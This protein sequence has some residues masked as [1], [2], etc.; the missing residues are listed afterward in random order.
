MWNCPSAP[1][2]AAFVPFLRASALC[3]LGP[4]V[5]LATAQA[6]APLNGA[7]IG[8]AVR[9]LTPAASGGLYWVAPGVLGHV[10]ADGTK[11]ILWDGGFGSGAVG[12]AEGSDGDPVVV[13]L[14][15]N[16]WRVP[17][18]GG[19][20]E[21]IYSDL[22]LIGQATDLIVDADGVF[23]IPCRTPSSGV[24]GIAAVDASAGG[25]PSDRRW[26]FWMVDLAH[27]PLA[28]AADAAADA[29]VM[30]DEGPFGALFGVDIE[31]ELGLQP[32]PAPLDGSVAFGGSI[33]A[34]DGDV[35]VESDGDAWIVAGDT[36]WFHDRL[37]GTTL[38]FQTG[39]SVV[40]RAVAIAPS[41]PSAVST[42]G[43]SLWVAERSTGGGQTQ[44]LEFPSVDPGASTTAASIGGVVDEGIPRSLS[45]LVLNLYTLATDG[46]GA[47]LYGGDLFQSDA[48]VRRLDPET[49][50]TEL[51]ARIPG[52]D[53]RIEGI[54][55]GP[56]GR[57]YAVSE[58]G[59]IWSVTQDPENPDLVF[60]D[61]L[62]QL[63]TNLPGGA[64][65]KGLEIDRQGNFYVAERSGFAA[66]KV[67]RVDAQTGAVELLAATV[68]SRG[69]TGDPFENRI[70][71]S[72]WNNTGFDG[73]LV[74]IQNGV[75]V[76]LPFA[77]SINIA[78]GAIWGDG[79]VL[80][81]SEG[82]VYTVAE[83]EFAVW[84]FDRESGRRTRMGSGYL[85]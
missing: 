14:D 55:I 39:T 5:G 11:T 51:L 8:G 10:A 74:E 85:N 28:F 64:A 58:R 79:D 19:S 23:L 26:S 29:L 6:D 61:A 25:G 50:A 66:G 56:D 46:Q 13:D 24:R 44:L 59:Q 73:T 35:A 67:S 84:R 52:P 57:I 82:G 68:D 54:E 2:G 70:L 33:N 49:G 27:Q 15:G 21:L 81:D 80:V 45:P 30:V 48:Q 32:I 12:V 34:F 41:S 7:S 77:G 75:A 78:N 36:L 71:A 60:D 83:D 40:R 72:E 4:W 47:L 22:F 38:P 17:A 63:A 53:G 9:D 20:R 16:L 37:A 65:T 3:L 18:A 69:V 62:D 31:G 76:D 1:L 42:T 43:Q